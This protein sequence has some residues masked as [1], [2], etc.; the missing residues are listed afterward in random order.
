MMT[1]L[2]RMPFGE[3]V[4]FGIV[5]GLSTLLYF[6]LL[7]VLWR[8]L[9][10]SLLAAAALS[11]GFGM[12]VNYVLQRGWTFRSNRRHQHA[13]PIFA[14]IH[15]VGLGLNALALSVFVNG[16]GV[17]FIVGQ[18]AALVLVIGWSYL[19]QKSFV[20]VSSW[21]NPPR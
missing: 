19:I 21:R 12:T 1:A 17:S 10:L 14:V 18:A 9:G 2:R 5:G 6:T 15:G 8:F 7:T 13:V 20:F 11:Y 16:L 4:R 3:L